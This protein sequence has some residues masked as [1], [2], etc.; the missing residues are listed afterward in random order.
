MRRDALAES[1]L[2]LEESAEL[3]SSENDIKC[4][5]EY[6]FLVTVVASIVK[7]YSGVCVLLS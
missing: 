1:V 4:R 3:Q 7:D 6:T 5:S 2:P